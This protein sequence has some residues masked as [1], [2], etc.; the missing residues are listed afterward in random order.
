M[1]K[2]MGNPQTSHGSKAWRQ[3]ET[4]GITPLQNRDRNRPERPITSWL[5]R[6]LTWPTAGKYNSKTFLIT[7]PLSV[8]LPIGACELQ[9]LTIFD[10]L[11]NQSPHL[12]QWEGGK[13]WGYGW[14]QD[15]NPGK[16][17]PYC[18]ELSRQSL[19]TE[20]DAIWCHPHISVQPSPYRQSLTNKETS[21]SQSLIRGY[22]CKHAE[23]VREMLKG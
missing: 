7:K 10:Q 19:K 13:H 6:N 22:L 4:L 15:S 12:Y 23:G 16:L 3:V 21:K 8:S 20:T 17:A 9:A 2:Y 18:S 1:V 11:F 5:A 14:P